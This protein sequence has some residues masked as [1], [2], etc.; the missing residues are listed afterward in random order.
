MKPRGHMR[1]LSAEARVT[2]IQRVAQWCFDNTE[3]WEPQHI[4]EDLAY[5]MWAIAQHDGAVVIP[6]RS[7]S[8][9][10]QTAAEV[11]AQNPNGLYETLVKYKIMAP[12]NEET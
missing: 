6:R 4:G 7:R 3:S 5:I 1:R 11:L 9:E 10:P 8:G 2:L 12:L